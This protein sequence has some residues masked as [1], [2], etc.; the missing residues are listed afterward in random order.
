MPRVLEIHHPLISHDNPV[1]YVD[2]SYPCLHPP[3]PPSA[4][5]PITYADLGGIETVLADIREL[6]EY[7]LKHPEVRPF[8]IPLWN[9]TLGSYPFQT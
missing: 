5:K 4:A 6:I 3:S 9:H 1:D 8:I 2:D 7:P